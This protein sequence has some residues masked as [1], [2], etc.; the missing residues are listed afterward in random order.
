NLLLLDEPF[1][2]LD[3][4]VR[5]KLRQDLLRVHAEFKIPII[6]VTHNLTD[7]FELADKVAI[8]NEGK[9]EQFGSKDEVFYRPQTRN[10][11]RFVET[12]NIFDLVVSKCSDSTVE[13]K[14]DKL[15]LTVETK[16]DLNVG[17][18]VIAT[19]RPEFIDLLIED[20]NFKG[21]NIYS[22]I[23]RRELCKGAVTRLFINLFNQKD[24]DL[25]VDIPT[26]LAEKLKLNEEVLVNLPKESMHIII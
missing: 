23:L 16:Q 22:G 13:V 1:S 25:I 4:L 12:K 7:V 19:I 20:S 8:Y 18:K 11:A 17:D 6:Y 21:D 10:V 3:T 2:A 26:L 9:I 5:E 15:K 24:F 14:N